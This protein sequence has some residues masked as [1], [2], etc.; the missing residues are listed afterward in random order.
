VASRY[1]NAG[2][3]C[4]AAKRFIVVDKIAEEFV[5][6]FATAVAALKTGNPADDQTTLAPMARTDLRDELHKQVQASVQAGANV[7]TG[8]NPVDGPGAFYEA[9]ILDQVEPGMAAYDEELFGP[10]AAVIRARD[11]DHALSIANSSRFGL[12]GSVWTQ[13]IEKGEQFARQL[14]SGS[15]FVNGMVKSDARLPFGGVKASGY[16]RELSHHGLREF[17]NIKTIWIR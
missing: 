14:Q 7:V 9:T 6:R 17:V 13:S 16:G 10:V 12:G 5:S 2:Q 8:G 4:I 1:L 15:A 11:E 3:S